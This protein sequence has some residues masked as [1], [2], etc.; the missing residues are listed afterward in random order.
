MIE[1]RIHGRGGMGAVTASQILAIA[2]FNE[3]KESQ[4]FPFFGVERGGA[5]VQAFVRIDDKKINLRTH[6]YKPDYVIVLDSSLLKTVNCKEGLKKDIIINS[7][8][9]IKGSYCVDITKVAMEK[10]GKPFVN[11]AILGAFCA[12]TNIIS[13][14]SL[15][16]AID[17]RVENKEMAKKN[18][19]T[20]KNIYEIAKNVKKN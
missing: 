12:L 6:V 17:E 14:E 7:S 5:P 18:K 2:A 10:I 15:L 13:I 9:K 20:V 1:I 16:K 8:K 4:A 19:E 11:L 3:G